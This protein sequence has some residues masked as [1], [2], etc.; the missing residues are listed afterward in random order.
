[1]QNQLRVTA[2]FYI[3]CIGGMNK[4]IQTKIYWV[5]NHTT[6]ALIIAKSIFL[7][8]VS[9]NCNDTN[10]SRQLNCTNC[11]SCLCL[12]F[13]LLHYA[14]LSSQMC[15]QWMTA[16]GTSKTFYTREHEILKLI[17]CLCCYFDMLYS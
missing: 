6:S 8:L 11:S 9:S 16:D 1:M 12:S 5:H 10:V 14:M 4:N 3:F 17:I 13:F 15:T 7:F 2:H